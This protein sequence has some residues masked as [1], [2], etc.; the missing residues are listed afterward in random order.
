MVASILQ[1]KG[2]RGRAHNVS[3]TARVRTTKDEPRKGTEARE[4]R[5]KQEAKG[6]YFDN[7]RRYI[8]PFLPLWGVLAPLVSSWE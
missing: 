4:A 2:N 8:Y 3:I 5:I 7:R 1:G 6:I